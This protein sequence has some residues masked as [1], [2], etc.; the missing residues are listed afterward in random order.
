MIYLESWTSWLMEE[1]RE[2]DLADINLK[3]DEMTMQNLQYDLITCREMGHLI[4]ILCNP[5]E[6]RTTM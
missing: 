6:I 2:T 5:G 1:K 4:I 3:Y